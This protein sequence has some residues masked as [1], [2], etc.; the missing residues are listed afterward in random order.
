[1][2]HND[3]LDDNDGVDSLPPQAFG[4]AGDHGE[5]NPSD[6]WL[7]EA[8]REEQ[9]LAM[10]LWFC[11]RFCDPAMETPYDSGE[12]GY[13]YIHGGPF[14]PDDEL[15]SRFGGIVDD[16]VI[17]EVVQDLYGDVGQDWAPI[18]YDNPEDYDDRFDLSF[19]RR[20]EL[21]GK[22]KARLQDVQ[23]VSQLEGKSGAKDL[24][25]MLAYSAAITVLEAF[26]SETME[27]WVEDDDRV[28]RSLVTKCHALK[29]KELQLGDIFDRHDGIKMEVKGFLQG[30]VWH[31]LKVVAGLFK[32]GLGVEFGDTKAIEAALV[33]RHD[34]VHRGGYNKLGNAITVTVEDLAELCDQVE[35]FAVHIDQQIEPLRHA[36]E[37]KP[38]AVAAPLAAPASEDF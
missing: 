17:E 7:R 22:L 21:L 6:A 32:A 38:G 24:A 34:I 11:A 27:T 23:A 4:E 33:K 15:G 1:M 37:P 12:G 5:F 14:D 35:G 20:D 26:L 29:T 16:D 18:V 10:R 19:L 9:M 13:I 3:H 2:G 28:L 30:I 36:P 8:E 25:V 31:R